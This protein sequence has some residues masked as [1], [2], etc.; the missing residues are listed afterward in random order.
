MH[1]PRCSICNNKLHLR[2]SEMHRPR[3]SICNNKLHLRSSEMQRSNKLCNIV[4]T[5]GTNQWHDVSE[6]YNVHL[7]QSTNFLNAPL[8]VN[9]VGTDFC[10]CSSYCFYFVTSL[11]L[12]DNCFCPNTVKSVSTK[13]YCNIQ[14]LL[15]L[16]FT[17]HSSKCIMHNNILQMIHNN[18]YDMLIW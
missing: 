12:V 17:A 1:R 16:G 4:A 13:K 10:V 5:D 15:V 8:I 3:C 2:S 6:I 11:A 7:Y 9:L 14:Y 18:E